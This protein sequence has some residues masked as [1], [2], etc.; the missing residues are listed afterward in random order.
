[1]SLTHLFRR[2]V[3]LS[4]PLL[5]LSCGGSSI[6]EPVEAARFLP[7]EAEEVETDQTGASRMVASGELLV[8]LREEATEAEIAA[9]KSV[10]ALWGAR[11]AAFDA[12][13]YVM[14]VRGAVTP[15]LS[16]EVEGLAGVLYVGKN[17]RAEPARANPAPGPERAAAREAALARTPPTING[18]WWVEAIRADD[19]WNLTEGSSG[20]TVAVVD[21]DFPF[22]QELIDEERVERFD[23]L[24]RPLP[25]PPPTDPPSFPVAETGH[26]AGVAAFALGS[27]L[28]LANYGDWFNEGRNVCG[29]DHEAGLAF[30]ALRETRL[31]SSGEAWVTEVLTSGETALGKAELVAIPWSADISG[32][33]GAED[34]KECGLARQRE[35]RSSLYPLA[36]LARERDRLIVFPAG[37][38][39][40]DTDDWL[41]EFSDSLAEVTWWELTLNV[42]SSSLNFDGS[43]TSSPF[44]RSGWMVDLYAPGEDTGFAQDLVE[45]YSD[46]PSA[47]GTSYASALAL[48]VAS[49]VKA[50]EPTLA[51][52]EVKTALLEG[53]PMAVITSMGPSSHLDARGAV[54]MAL[55]LD[56]AD[57]ERAELVELAGSDD[58][59]V[60]SL[61]LSVPANQYTGLDIFFLIDVTGSFDGRL[62]Y[63]VEHAR[64]LMNMLNSREEDVAF[65]LAAFSD[66][67]FEPY[68][69][70]Q[71]DDR[72]FYLLEPITTDGEEVSDALGTLYPHG[73]SDTEEAQL[74]ALH[75][76]ATGEGWDINGDGFYGGAGE[77]PPQNLGWRPGARKVVVLFT[78]ATF[79]DSGVEPGY[80]GPTL[81][82]TLN[83][84][85]QEEVV[86]VLMD[87]DGSS[88]MAPLY[89]LAEST[90]GQGF[91]MPDEPGDFLGLMEGALEFESPWIRVWHRVVSGSEYVVSIEPTEYWTERGE[92]TPFTLTLAGLPGV[93]EGRPQGDEVVVWFYTDD[94]VFARRRFPVRLTA[95]E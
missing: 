42:G 57:Y 41:F 62:S 26:G 85:Y 30:V 76:L 47:D 59:K 54:E 45:G 17:T 65:G 5:L 20:V 68:G 2:A 37:N 66:F 29:V 22:G 48:G 51:A 70:A 89:E 27:N 93:A 10:L 71:F 90:G 16:W 60:I 61:P 43:L 24:G 8:F 12:E 87:A 34:P 80:P 31:D 58:F 79:H 74:A 38:D 15:E 40:A 25:W 56:R 78:D 28:D 73:G 67:P 11:V 7:V 86:V 75:Q 21:R 33:G 18:G 77:L 81:D 44:S 55:M 53:A 14:Q 69:D 52:S 91:Y 49:L 72:P 36:R 9:I 35:F 50:V 23:H 13:L 82:Q 92:D 88:Y 19:A 4:L 94:T 39:G 63:S 6:S 95:G 46:E 1:M 83:A 64:A 32:C 3:S 84:L